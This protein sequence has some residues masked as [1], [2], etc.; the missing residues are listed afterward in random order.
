M[1]FLDEKQFLAPPRKGC[2]VRARVV[3]D[4]YE[5]PLYLLVEDDASL[6]PRIM[7]FLKSENIKCNKSARVA[8]VCHSSEEER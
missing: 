3:L 4:N 1:K 7:D 8:L 2:E 5:E 6:I